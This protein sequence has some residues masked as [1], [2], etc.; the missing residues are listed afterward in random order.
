L[1]I[2]RKTD[3]YDSGGLSVGIDNV[4]WQGTFA[5]TAQGIT[6][7]WKWG[8]AV[9]TSF[10][11]DYNALGVK[12]VDDN[13]ASQYRNSDHA[14]SPENFKSFVIEVQL[15]VADQIALAGTAARPV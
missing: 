2:R 6:V 12:P 14:G 10:S 15:E 5:S 3:V 4:T 1:L 7:N 9:Y 13:K 11:T 8:A